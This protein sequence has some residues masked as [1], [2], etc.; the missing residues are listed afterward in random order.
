MSDS[1]SRLVRKA[2]L[3]FK[4]GA[5]RR[6]IPVEMS[7][8]EWWQLWAPHWHQRQRMSMRGMEIVMGRHGDVG[9]YSVGNVSMISRR[10]NAEDA[11]CYRRARNL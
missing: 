3:A 9:P 10:R 11:A 5:K 8:E 7:F 1:H 6:G 4:A 2:W